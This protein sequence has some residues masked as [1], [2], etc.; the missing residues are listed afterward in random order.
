M[1]R[2]YAFITGYSWESFTLFHWWSSISTC[3]TK[4][5]PYGLPFLFF[6]GGVAVGSFVLGLLI[7]SPIWCHYFKVVLPRFIDAALELILNFLHLVVSLHVL[8]PL[9]VALVWPV[10]TRNEGGWIGNYVCQE[11]E[12]SLVGIS[13]T[14]N[15]VL[16]THH[17]LEVLHPFCQMS[18]VFISR[19]FCYLTYFSD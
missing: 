1:K 18:L 16:N 12:F 19:A 7:S 13:N 8:L 10:K 3:E 9:S 2:Q 4:H 17:L 14:L 5:F 6:F 11:K 15:T